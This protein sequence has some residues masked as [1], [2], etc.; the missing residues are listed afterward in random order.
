MTPIRGHCRITGPLKTPG[1]RG[2]SLHSLDSGGLA[3]F[4]STA[5]ILQA[6]TRPRSRVMLWVTA[7][8]IKWPAQKDNPRSG[9][10]PTRRSP[11]AWTQFIAPAH[12][13][14]G[15]PHRGDVGYR[16]SAAPKSQGR[17]PTGAV[18][19]LEK[20]W[21][22]DGAIDRPSGSCGGPSPKGLGQ[23]RGEHKRVSHW[24]LA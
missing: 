19:G 20:Q 14:E 10:Y 15:R 9:S 18:S 6:V 7:A 23:D 17:I 2:P 13:G 3:R 1:K 5:L 12:R 24:R 11:A 4:K 16:V 8:T 22:T 21:E